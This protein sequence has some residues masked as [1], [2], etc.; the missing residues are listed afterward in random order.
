MS[1]SCRLLIVCLLTLLI[2]ACGGEPKDAQKFDRLVA[3]IDLISQGARYTTR[4]SANDKKTT[5]RGDR[6]ASAPD[7]SLRATLGYCTPRE[8]PREEYFDYFA[9]HGDNLCPTEQEWSTSISIARTSE[10]DPENIRVQAFGAEGN[11]LDALG[12]LLSPEQIAALAESYAVIAACKDQTACVEYPGVSTGRHLF[13]P[14]KTRKDC[15]GVAE[16][17]AALAT[18]ASKPTFE[19]WTA[20]RV[21]AAT[22]PRAVRSKRD[23]REAAA[24]I[25]ERLTQASFGYEL[26]DGRNFSMELMDATLT[27]DGLLQTSL[28]Y[29]HVVDDA[30]LEITT[31]NTGVAIADLSMV[32]PN[33]IEIIKAD[34][35]Q[36]V[37]VYNCAGGEACISLAM[38]SMTDNSFGWLLTCA[39]NLACEQTERD[40]RALVEYAAPKKHER[41]KHDDKRLASPTTDREQQTINPNDASVPK[42]IRRAYEKFNRSIADAKVLLLAAEGRT[43]RVME[44]RGAS[45]DDEGR[46]IAHRQVCLALLAL[47]VNQSSECGA[48]TLFQDYDLQINLREL[49]PK[50]IAIYE[51]STNTGEEGRWLTASCKAQYVCAQIIIPPNPAHLRLQSE[52]IMRS[53]LETQTAPKIRIPCAR[54]SDCDDAA[55]ALRELIRKAPKRKRSKKKR[56]GGDLVGIWDYQSPFP[57]GWVTEFRRDGTFVFTNA[58]SRTEGTYEARDGVFSQ[59]APQFNFEDQGTYRF[60]DENT[61]ELTG[62]YGASTW[63]RRE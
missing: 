49:D 22:A 32:D 57:N 18:L 63:K 28:Q 51:A 21:E 52:T 43:A 15:D 8:I 34:L 7:G 62:R 36:M 24:D 47:D 55:A 40:L 54:K 31:K 5:F 3:E 48:R 20:A 53:L 44:G 30:C 33:S 45:V 61:V 38:D 26:S 23:G 56:R 39:D 46:L 9:K 25:S 60:I 29:C 35:N 1:S 10:I 19:K 4:N 59:Q 27:K 2:A 13:V 17:L 37:V 42:G 50:S 16:N 6:F 58:N 12:F 41:D 14:C 11:T